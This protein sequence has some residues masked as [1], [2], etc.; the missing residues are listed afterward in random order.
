MSA[1]S[2]S[3]PDV[4]TH[5]VRAR[6]DDEYYVGGWPSHV[7]DDIACGTGS[8]LAAVLCARAFGGGGLR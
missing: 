5:A 8:G 7:R 2:D 6:I 4:T 3:Y 1:Q